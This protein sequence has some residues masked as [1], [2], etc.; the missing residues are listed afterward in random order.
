MECPCPDA[1]IVGRITDFVMG[2]ELRIAVKGSILQPFGHQRSGVL[3]AAEEKIPSGV[4]PGCVLPIIQKEI[5]QEPQLFFQIGFMGDGLPE[6]SPDKIPLLPVECFIAGIDFVYRALD[7]ELGDRM[8]QF[9]GI[10]QRFGNARKRE[11][12]V[13]QVIEISGHPLKQNEM[14]FLIDQVGEHGPIFVPMVINGV[15]TGRI[16][17]VGEQVVE[18]AAEIITGGA[19]YGPSGF[20]QFL[21][22]EDLFNEDIRLRAGHLPEPFEILNRVEEPVDMI[23]A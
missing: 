15:E 20:H 1:E 19:L 8:G 2:N 3:H 10:G 4:A 9:S 16:A 6:N 17:L 12:A 18:K 22:A 21:P 14:F 13:E 7:Q 11:A 5:L 23:H